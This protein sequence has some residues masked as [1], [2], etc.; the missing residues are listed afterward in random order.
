MYITILKLCHFYYISCC[1]NQFIILITD[2]LCLYYCCSTLLIIGYFTLDEMYVTLFILIHLLLF[3]LVTLCQYKFITLLIYSLNQLCSFYILLQNISLCI[4]ISLFFYFQLNS[5]FLNNILL[6]FLLNT[7]LQLL[8][9]QSPSLISNLISIC[10]LNSI[11]LN[12]SCNISLLHN[13]YGSKLSHTIF[14]FYNIKNT[15]LCF[16]E[17][18]FWI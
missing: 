13:I 12:H 10:I 8:N 1:F 17:L 7:S 15:C 16:Y 2:Y 14:T 11:T 18:S 4:F 3:V 5:S 6:N 9:L